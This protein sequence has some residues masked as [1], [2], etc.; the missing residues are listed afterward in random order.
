MTTIVDIRRQKV[1]NRRCGSSSVL[2]FEIQSE[3][4]LLCD[5]HLRVSDIGDG[6]R[7]QA[8]SFRYSRRLS[9]KCWRKNK[10]DD[11]SLHWRTFGERSVVISC[12]TT[13]S[14]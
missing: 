11:H 13:E 12:T 3:L 14:N 9:L 6:H 5:A 2:L 1:N 7:M 10:K 4:G 8:V